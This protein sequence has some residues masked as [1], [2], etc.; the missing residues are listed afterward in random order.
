VASETDGGGDSVRP[1]IHI[2]RLHLEGNPGPVNK[3]NGDRPGFVG[4]DLSRQRISQY[5][6]KGC[7]FLL[8]RGVFISKNRGAGSQSRA[9]EA[10]TQNTDKISLQGNLCHSLLPTTLVFVSAAVIGL[11]FC[12]GP[13]VAL[14]SASPVRS[15]PR[16]RKE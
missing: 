4:E 13:W 10:E 12:A 9:S 7:E 3:A 14:D 16:I 2:L 11:L 8:G 5:I 6:S 15:P 1:A